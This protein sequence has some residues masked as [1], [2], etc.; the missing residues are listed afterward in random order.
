MYVFNLLWSVFKGYFSTFERAVYNC[1]VPFLPFRTLCYIVAIHFTFQF[2]DTL[3]FCSNDLNI[4]KGDLKVRGGKVLYLSTYYH[5]FPPGTIWVI[6]PIVLPVFGTARTPLKGAADPPCR[7]DRARGV[8]S[9]ESVKVLDL[10]RE[11]S[12]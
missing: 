4:F 10:E 11:N 1:T 12:F 9:V 6:S 8:G 3:L 5:F 2:H 7:I